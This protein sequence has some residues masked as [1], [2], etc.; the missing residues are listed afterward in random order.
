MI[1]TMVASRLGKRLL[2]AAGALIWLAI[3]AGPFVFMAITSFKDQFELLTKSLWALPAEPSIENFRLVIEND[4][5]VFVRN[6]VVVVSISTVLILIVS[7]MAA[8]VFSRFSFRF[9]SPLFALVVAGLIVPVHITLIPIF[10]LTHRIGLFDSIWGLI[11][12]YVAFQVPVTVF[13]LTGFMQS[14]P[15]EI[16]EA[17]RTDGAGPV[18]RF[19]QVVLPLSRPGL[20]T[21]AIYNAVLLWNEFVFAFVLTT[22][23]SNRTLPLAIWD[24]QGVYGQ[25]TPVI[26]AVL[27]LT[28]MPL[29]VAYILL[30]E[31]MIKGIM[32]GALKG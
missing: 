18:R 24:F 6:S 14:I 12:P 25:D 7:S 20:I 8:Y 17:A 23:R 13:I 30:Q 29:V 28:A 9:R 11:G 21:V 5:F 4:L 3:A 16:E 2:L 32:A 15:R 27:V 31:Q 10:V 26:M 1:A 22:S 19:V